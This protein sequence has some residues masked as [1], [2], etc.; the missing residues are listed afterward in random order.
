MCMGPTIASDFAAHR[1]DEAHALEM[2]SCKT[3]TNQRGHVTP[4]AVNGPDHLFRNPDQ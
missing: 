4:L 2:R 1:A 3:T